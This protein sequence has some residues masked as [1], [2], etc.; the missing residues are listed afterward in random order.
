MPRSPTS[1]SGPTSDG[2]YRCAV[3]VHRVHLLGPDQLGRGGVAGSD[4][5]EHVAHGV[6]IARVCF[7]NL[8]LD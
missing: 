8:C 1:A 3:L 6:H 2:L 4:G 5:G 7:E